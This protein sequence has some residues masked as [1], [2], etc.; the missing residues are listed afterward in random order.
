M[1]FKPKIFLHTKLG[2]LFGRPKILSAENKQVCSRVLAVGK[3]K[4]AISVGSNDL[5]SC[6]KL[7]RNSNHEQ[8]ALPF[9]KIDFYHMA[10]VGPPSLDSQTVHRISNFSFVAIS[11]LSGKGQEVGNQFLFCY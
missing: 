3:C 2:L 7:W 9:N 1:H 6:R 5:Q 11:F 10:P 4:S 8:A